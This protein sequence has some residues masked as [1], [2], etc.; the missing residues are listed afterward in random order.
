[1]EYRKIKS[2]ILSAKSNIKWD[3]FIEIINYYPKS[4]TDLISDQIHGRILEIGDNKS[5]YTDVW[6]DFT[7]TPVEKIPKPTIINNLY[8]IYKNIPP[9]KIIEDP[10]KTGQAMNETGEIV[11]IPGKAKIT[12]KVGDLRDYDLKAELI[13]LCKNLP[14]IIALYH[15]NLSS[16]N[17]T[18]EEYLEEMEQLKNKMSGDLIK[19]DELIKEITKE[20]YITVKFNIGVVITPYPDY[21][22]PEKDEEEEEEIKKKESNVP[23]LQPVVNVNETDEE[24][25]HRE[26]LLKSEHDKKMK[27]YKIKSEKEENE[28]RD[29]ETKKKLYKT[30]VELFNVDVD[31]VV[32]E[33]L[34]KLHMLKNK[35]KSTGYYLGNLD[36]MISNNHKD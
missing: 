26:F 22:F 31:T 4:L 15:E 6:T 19:I 25:L 23:I 12:E 32:I 35:D 18:E 5:M 7:R 29:I 34:I 30:R 28:K 13:K 21:P 27:E 17:N 33:E 9:D 1:M 14:N 2:I 11:T 8:F 3:D 20:K 10:E 24:R 16:K 36:V